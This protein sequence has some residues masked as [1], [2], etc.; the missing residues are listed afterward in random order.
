VLPPSALL[1]PLSLHLDVTQAS[2]ADIHAKIMRAIE[3]RDI[4]HEASVRATQEQYTREMATL[5]EELL[6]ARKR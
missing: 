2:Q 6:E 4:L 3:E 1:T 5:R